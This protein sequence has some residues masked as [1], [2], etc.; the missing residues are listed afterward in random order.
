MIPIRAASKSAKNLKIR[1][2]ERDTTPLKPIHLPFI[3][4]TALKVFTTFDPALRRNL[5]VLFIAGLLF[6]SGLAALLPTLPL[7]IKA[8]GATDQLV[9][10]VMACFA[11]GLIPPRGWLARLADNRGRKL[12]LL[13]GMVAVAIAP[14]GYLLT[15]SIPALMAIRAFHGLSIAAFALA[16]STLVV[17]LSPA[18]QRGE[19]IGYMSLVTPIG[20]AVGPA[21][22]GF[23]YDW[24][25]FTPMFLIAAS[26]GMMG[27][28]CT[29]QVKEVSPWKPTSPTN[30]TATTQNQP[31]QN[32]PNQNQ[33]DQ[34]WRLL[35]SPR[36]RIPALVLLL[37][38]FTF[39]GLSTFVALFIKDAGVDLNVGLFFAAAA[40]ASFVVRLI[41][42]P[43]SDRHGR[44][45][46][47][48]LSLVFYVVAMLLLWTANSSATFLLA[49][50]VE[51]AGAGTLIP[52]IAAL[53]ADRSYPDER[54]RTFGVCMLG[55]DAGIA[56]AGPL[57]GAIAT[58][59]GY[60][61]IFG[62]SAGLALLGLLIFLTQSSKDLAHSLRFALGLGTDLH[63]VDAGTSK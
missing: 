3:F 63:A 28:V 38:G 36:I 31:D 13:I 21:I 49:G 39:G 41:V 55:F 32:Q 8:T 48:S 5:L 58:Q 25:G 9:G 7:Y 14:L 54:G 61:S 18:H 40:I 4:D 10:I 33:S 62:I 34:F 12:V 60:R 17:D 44:G 43:A 22:G 19:V 16:Y 47:I 57:L 6:W 23:S 30:Q 59:L 51:G 15:S 24:F 1:H 37:V 2:D 56:L 11:I 50:A 52:M 45:I 27:L 29:M 26:L 42:G 46:F 35:G 20:M 53:M